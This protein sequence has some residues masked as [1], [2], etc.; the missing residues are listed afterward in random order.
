[1]HAPPVERHLRDVDVA[2]L[3][4]FARSTLAKMRMRGD[5]PRFTK[6][7]RSVR[8]AESALREWLAALP[9]RRSTSDLGT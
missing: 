4:G 7:G 2:Q 1:M 9:R 6:H 3:T 8:Y 5:G